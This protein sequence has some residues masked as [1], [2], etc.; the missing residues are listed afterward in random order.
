[1]LEGRGVKRAE[2]VSIFWLAFADSC[3]PCTHTHYLW[4]PPPLPAGAKE[5]I[6]VDIVEKLTAIFDAGGHQK[7]GSIVGAIQ[8]RLTGGASTT[9]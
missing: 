9:C 3:L 6:F 1:M 8:V 4:P 5:E 2:R 7:S